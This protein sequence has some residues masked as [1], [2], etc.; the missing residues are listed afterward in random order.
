MVYC[1]QYANMQSRKVKGGDGNENRIQLQSERFQ[2]NTDLMCTRFYK[3]YPFIALSAEHEK[4]KRA[5]L[6][7][8]L[9]VNLLG[10][11][12]GLTMPPASESHPDTSK[13]S[14]CA[15]V[16]AYRCHHHGDQHR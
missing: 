5:P 11:T 1:I 3:I 10:F 14:S 8:L 2:R 12:T 9:K 16:P 15:C 4:Q 7:P 6:R 13:S